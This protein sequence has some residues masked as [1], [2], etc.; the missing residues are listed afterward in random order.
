MSNFI[1]LFRGGDAQRAS[2]SPEAMQKHMQ[3]WAAWIQE[4]TKT[5][6]FKAGDPL[7]GAGKVVHG[8]KKVI[9]DGPYAEAKDLVGGYLLITANDINQALEL[10][11]GCPIFDNDGSVEIRPVAQ[12]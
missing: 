3:K 1:Y 9:T 7:D 8:K 12:M 2:L 5:G 6:N 10:S 11:K 4:L